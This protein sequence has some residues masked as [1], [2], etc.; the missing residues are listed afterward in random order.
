MGRYGIAVD[1]RD[2]RI[3]RPETRNPCHVERIPRQ[4]R[5]VSGDLRPRECRLVVAR[6]KSRIAQFFHDQSRD[7]GLANIRACACNK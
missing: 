3:L 4:Q 6:P 2:V 5:S 7:I 1:V